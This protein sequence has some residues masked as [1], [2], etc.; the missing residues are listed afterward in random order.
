[1]NAFT[2]INNK[3]V[4]S[5]Q[6]ADSKKRGNK[7]TLKSTYAMPYLKATFTTTKGAYQAKAGVITS[8]VKGKIVKQDVPIFVERP[9]TGTFI[10]SYTSV[11]SCGLRR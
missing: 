1:M 8:K 7:L 5:K 11:F 9:V 4:S 2:E 3:A 6:D 10:M